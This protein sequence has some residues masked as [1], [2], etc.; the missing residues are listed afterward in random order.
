MTAGAYL[1]WEYVADPLHIQFTSS[2]HHSSRDA[3]IDDSGH[4][5]ELKLGS[6]P[7]LVQV[8]SMAVRSPEDRVQIEEHLQRAEYIGDL[9]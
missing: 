7:D 2:R 5:L 3:Y 8:A 1:D 6:F 9:V 4:S